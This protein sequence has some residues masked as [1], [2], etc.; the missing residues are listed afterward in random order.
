MTTPRTPESAS[1]PPRPG[2]D[3]LVVTA[4]ETMLALRTATTGPIAVGRRYQASIAGC[5]TNV[6]IGLARLGHRVRWVGRVG[7]DDP[8]RLIRTTL[9]GEGIDTTHIVTDDSAATGLLIRTP[10]IGTT[11]LVHYARSGSAGSRLHAADLARA[12]TADVTLLHLSGI[13][14]AISSSADDAVRHAIAH[15][16]ATTSYDVNYRRRLSS[17]AEAG[18]RLRPLLAHL[19]ILFCGDDELSVLQAA[20]GSARPIEAALEHGVGEV[21]V[22][23]GAAGA[24]TVTTTDTHTS[25]AAPATA[26][27]LVGAG[28]AFAAGYLSAH[29]DG[30]DIPSRLHRAAVVAGFCVSTDGDWEGLPSRSDLDLIRQPGGAPVR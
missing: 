6:A 14:Q 23:R 30:A 1:D 20:T 22:K 27:D 5:E 21:V 28:D 29:L 26:V 15:T 25:P 4:G 19:D 8:G 10:R 16:A 13:T 11:T 18:Q 2:A 9:L 7:A 17:A 12:L 24:S 3:H